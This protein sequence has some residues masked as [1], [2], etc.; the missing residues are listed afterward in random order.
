MQMKTVKQIMSIALCV[1]I[2][3]MTGFAF[4]TIH[5]QNRSGRY[6]SVTTI[7]DS[8]R[9]WIM[10]R[11]GRKYKSI[12]GYISTVQAYA[13]EYFHYND[14]KRP[15]FQ[16]F[17]FDDIVDGDDIN[18]AL[19]FDFAVLF[20][21]ITLVLDEENLLPVEDIK[22]YVADVGPEDIFKLRHS[23]NIILLPD[24]ERNYCIDLTTSV[25][26]AE[27][28]FKPKD[29][30]EIFSCGIEEFCEQHDEN[31]INLH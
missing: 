21:H 16:Y 2:L 26:R 11:F 13:R 31:L 3:A 15:L 23:Y 12:E 24:E 8:E 27:K 1:A 4:Y 14:D 25:L 19:C 28:G 17:D 10:E 5:A 29:D 22:V 7:S 18:N 30:Y 6:S 9:E 20:K